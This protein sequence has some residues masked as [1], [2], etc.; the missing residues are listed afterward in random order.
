MAF[1]RGALAGVTFALLVMAGA[2]SEERVLACPSSALVSH[3]RYSP[4]YVSVYV[5]SRI[6]ARLAT[7]R[8]E[9][10]QS[11]RCEHLTFA[12]HPRPTGQNGLKGGGA[13]YSDAY[14]VGLDVW[15]AHGTE[16][17][18]D[19]TAHLDFRGL[20]KGGQLLV[21]LSESFHFHDGN[22]HPTYCDSEPH[23]VYETRVDS[24]DL[25]DP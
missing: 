20:S 1:P 2:C 25:L 3:D 17:D 19:E 16:W 24:G 13:L 9:L 12:A 11:D 18:L 7:I 23:L 10:C 22:D 8:V 14:E 4:D 15:N 5:D 6:R 21:H